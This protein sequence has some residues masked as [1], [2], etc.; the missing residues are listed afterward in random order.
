[1]GLIMTRQRSLGIAIMVVGMVLPAACEQTLRTGR[2]GNTRNTPNV[3]G[4]CPAALTLCGQGAFARCLDLQN[5]HQHC[6]ACDNACQSGI[7]CTVGT[8]QQVACTG[9]VTVSTQTIPGTAPSGS[10]YFADVNGDGIQDLVSLGPSNGVNSTFQV[11]LGEA[12]GGFAAATPYQISWPSD[13]I[14]A[15]AVGD[16]NGDGFQDLYILGRYGGSAW[17]VLWLGHADGKLTLDRQMDVAEGCTSAVAADLNGDGRLD[18]VANLF[19]RDGPT[20]F[21]ADANGE[22]HGGATYP[23]CDGL[24]TVVR[25]WNGDGFPDLVNLQDTL[26]V[27]LNKGNGTFDHGMDCGVAASSS[28]FVGQPEQVAVIGDFNRDGHPDLATTRDSTVDVLL[29]MGGCQFQPMV[30]Y[31]LTDHIQALSSGDVNGDGLLD[32]VALTKDTTISLLLGG[33]DGAFQV[34]PF[35]VGGVPGGGGSVMLGDVTGDGK[36]DIVVVPTAFVGVGG[37]PAQILENTCP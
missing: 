2:V 13:S 24:G 3:D 19:N 11:A 5:D 20:V 8:C 15:I 34:V 31:P 23:E 30:E 32:L 16:S 37:G 21:L 6:G 17:M 1:M 7:A 28:L 35:S 12:G 10:H 36:V 29:G 18:L 9:P 27:C 22:F 14:T 26:K 33:P 25:D 4:T